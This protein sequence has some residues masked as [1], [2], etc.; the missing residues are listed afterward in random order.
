MPFKSNDKGK[1]KGVEGKEHSTKL[2]AHGKPKKKVRFVDEPSYAVE[3]QPQA[4]SAEEKADRRAQKLAMHKL[5]LESEGEPDPQVSITP[6][7]EEY[8]ARQ[9]MESRRLVSSLPESSEPKALTAEQQE[10]EAAQRRH[11]DETVTN[12]TGMGVHIKKTI[13]RE[14]FEGIVKGTI[15]KGFGPPF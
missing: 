3:P 10:E 11:R 15:N 13:L 8:R 6:Q 2:H 12:M 1:G 14:P 9:Q 7:Q 4:P 5:V